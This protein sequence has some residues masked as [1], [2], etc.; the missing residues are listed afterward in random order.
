MD[1]ATKQ[2]IAERLSKQYSQD[3]AELLDEAVH[4]VKIREA[5]GINNEGLE[6]QIEFLLDS[7]YSEQEIVAMLEGH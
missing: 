4:D 3:D 7:G 1:R 5:A 6:T 2:T